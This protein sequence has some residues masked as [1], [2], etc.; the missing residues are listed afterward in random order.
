MEVLMWFLVL[1]GSCCVR[2]V[3]LEQG[4]IDAF[5]VVLVLGHFLCC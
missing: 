3:P 2:S 4:V 1:S 5:L